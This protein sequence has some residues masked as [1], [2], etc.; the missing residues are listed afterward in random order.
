MVDRPKLNPQVFRKPSSQGVP[1]LSAQPPNFRAAPSVSSFAGKSVADSF[2]SMADDAK[3]LQA[4]SSQQFQ[5]DQRQFEVAQSEIEAN[6][7]LEAEAEI[8][9]AKLE[10]QRQ[11][12]E[13]RQNG[14]P[15]TLA[16][17]SS[18][19]YDDV[20]QQV[21]NERDLSEYQKRYLL[22]RIEQGK[23]RMAENALQYQAELRKVEQENN[24]RE[25]LDA[26]GITTYNNPK[27]LRAEIEVIRNSGQM[28]RLSDPE[29]AKVMDTV[30]KTLADQ[31]VRGHIE[32]SPSE[33]LFLLESGELDDIITGDKKAQYIDMA[34]S[35][36]G[37]AKQ[38]QTLDQMVGAA[39]FEQ[40]VR[41]D[42]YSITDDDLRL[43]A[44]A[45]GIKDSEVKRLVGL[46]ESS[47]ASLLKDNADITY[48]ANLIRSGVPVNSQ[49][50]EDKKAF[51]KAYEAMLPQISALPYEQRL[52]SSVKI[53]SDNRVIPDSLRGKVELA[54]TSNDPE[55]VKEAVDLLSRLESDVET[56]YLADKLITGRPRDRL[57]RVAEQ[58]RLGASTFDEAVSRV[59]QQLSVINHSGPAVREQIESS[60]KK[61][62]I[63]EHV[64]GVFAGS[65]DFIPFV[66]GFEEGT[67]PSEEQIDQMSVSWRLEYENALADT[68]N[69]A[70]ARK[71]ANQRIKSR[72]GVSSVTGRSQF[73]QFPPE[74]VVGIKGQDNSWMKRQIL[75]YVEEVATPDNILLSPEDFK[76]MKDRIVLIPDP[77]ITPKTYEDNDPY[78]HIGFLSEAGNFI[79]IN[80]ENE[81]FHFDAR[82][83]ALDIVDAKRSR[84]ATIVRA[85]EII[86]E[87]E[88]RFGKFSREGAK[89]RI[90]AQELKR[91][92]AKARRKAKSSKRNI[93]R[94]DN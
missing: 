66:G 30:E 57:E 86:A 4:M 64:K 44:E 5:F 54:A 42:P 90:E 91:D 25:A 31:A 27:A 69:E 71:R 18:A 52:A 55:Q 46:R 6:Q 62:D 51:N 82:A 67:G 60:L 84:A 22:P 39:Q 63:R 93:Y 41:N 23:L 73:M 74:R 80:P 3:R 21:L 2:L 79:R 59:D 94:S 16:V 32:G 29:R 50:L 88:S 85:N 87:A 65:L 76:K 8:G 72:A 33:A 13:L 92:A 43:S 89:A 81:M 70:K 11:V 83:E 1:R 10:V 9:K 56:S 53:I 19:L 34:Q 49:I 7:E 78:Y 61:I 12:E 20:M 38:K 47:K 15:N 58:I 40:K 37:A 48:G 14:N 36:L 17:D 75:D 45:F 26:S 68:R 24:A 35:K 77:Q 28:Q